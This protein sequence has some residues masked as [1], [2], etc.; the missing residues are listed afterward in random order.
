MS[1]EQRGCSGDEPVDPVASEGRGFRALLRALPSSILPFADAATEEL[2]LGRLLR[3]SLFQVSVGM[4][5]VLLNGTLNRVMVVELGIPVWLVSMMVALPILFA[6]ARALIGHRSDHHVSA[7]GWRRVPYLWVGSM[8]QYGGLAMM[9]FAILTLSGGGQIQ[10]AYV[11]EITAALAFLMVG[12]GLHTVQTAGL[13][14][15]NDLAPESSRPRVVALLYV[16]LLIGMMVSAIAFGWVLRSDFRPTVLIQLIQGAAVF[17]MVLNT[18]ALWKQEV[19]HPKAPARGRL[20]PSFSKAWRE[21]AAG[22][23]APQLLLVVALGTAAFSMQDILLEP[24]GGEILKLSV[25]AT[26]ALTALWALGTLLGLALAARSLNKGTCPNLLAARGLIIGIPAFSAVVFADPL[27]SLTLF[28][29]GTFFIGFGGG[30]FAVGTLLAAMLLT[31]DHGSGLALGAWGAV[32]AAS[33]G[34]AILAG[35]LLRD[36]VTSLG[37]SGYLGAGFETPS[38]GYSFVYHLEIGLLFLTLIVI[39]PMVRL[40]RRSEGENAARFGLTELPG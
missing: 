37:L 20:R 39:G 13:A 14:L 22:G 2:P 35:G 19:R 40:T 33:A 11:G 24:Y 31:Q 15:A 12:F 10:V 29:L 28:R 16:M 9:P 3:L 8:M 1:E 26:T 6:P 30:L 36:A 5:V 17:T 4:A 38:I 18:I 27:M 32:Q 21:F 23:E 34:S 25:G 7:L